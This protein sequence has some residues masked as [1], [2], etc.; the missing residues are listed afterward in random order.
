[1]RL[2]NLTIRDFI[3]PDS[4][5]T[6]LAGAGCSIDPPSCLPAGRA[7]MDAIIDYSCAESEIE[8]IKKLKNLRFEAL[9]E[10]VREELDKELKII[11]FYGLCD[12][13]NLQH[14][15]IA[16]MIIKGH[17]VMTTNF[18]YLIEHALQQL[19]VPNDDIIPVITRED[20]EEFQD[21]NEQLKKGKKTVYKIHGSTKNIITKK[22]TRDSLIATIKAFGSNKEGENVF[23][24][25]SFKQPAFANIT[26]NRSLVIVGYSGSD[27]FDIVPT[28][29]VLKNLNNIIWIN[30][31]HDDEGKELIYEITTDV[32]DDPKKL[33]K[34]DQILVE[35]KRMNNKI[36]VCKINANT[37]RI[38]NEILDDK[39]KLSSEKF[40]VN[41]LDWLKK[42]ITLP[43][44]MMK[45]YISYKIYWDLDIYDKAMTCSEN[46][47][48]IAEKLGNLKGKATFLNNIGMIHNAQGNYPEALKRYKEALQIAEQLGD[49]AEK[50][51]FLNNIGMIHNAQGN[52]P[53]ALKR[54]EEALQIDEQ[55]GDLSGKATRLNNIG[56]IY[57]AQGNYPEALKQNEEALKI[58]EKLGNLRS[59]GTA[60]SN[61][62]MIYK[63]QG[64]Y[65][66]ALNRYEQALQ[67]AEKLGDLSGKAIFLNNIGMIHNAQGNYPEAL[68]RY[69][70]ALQIA[71]QL[72]DLKGKAT[73]LNNIASIHY[74]Q[75]NY[76]KAL[77]RYE[78][79][80]QIAEQL[81]DLRGKAAFLNN[82]GMIHYAKGNYP[83]ALKRYEEA[84]QI[85]EQLGDLS[86]KAI[87][88]NNIG[89]IHNAQG[90]YPEALRRYEEALQIAEQLGDL[91]GKAIRLN[92]IGT[93]YDTQENYPEALKRYEEALQ[94]DEQLGDL[95]GKA[96]D[97][98][99]IGKIYKAQGNYPKALKKLEEA[100]E[101]FTGLGLSKSPNA[102][103]VK[104]HIKTLKNK[105]PQN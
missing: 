75:R 68:R 103:N 50:A 5:L 79:A 104:K 77:R 67:I 59:K 88:L 81:R 76:P 30:Y 73:F 27:D 87:R 91:K 78:E 51:A 95:S 25:E 82:I 18:D 100:L 38:V 66:E 21:P 52:Y 28:L 24:L 105:F 37:H 92:N 22:P 4:K 14:F 17:F 29:K 63:A 48:R 96:I 71:E 72:G 97:L 15:F 42:N 6:F 90:N 94:I 101:I 35:I 43:S 45:Y 39:P 85:D 26:E 64:N 58:F 57:D 83:E 34:V 40:S 54:Y 84:L 53:E 23:Q 9:V 46:S 31:V 102:K 13:P 70:E 49:L 20:F 36:P 93:I 80:L 56:M 16:A 74:A 7:M 12:K 60:L 10:I 55:L 11:D 65:P 86:R 69:E 2:T 33:D 47:L 19:G 8:G 89:M 32:I 3:T 98:N 61:I 62:G 41:A 44:E 99:N 1:M